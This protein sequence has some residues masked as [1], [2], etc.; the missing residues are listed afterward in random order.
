VHGGV[1]PL[2]GVFAEVPN[3]IGIGSDIPP[4]S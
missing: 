4:A 2:S 3:T 1:P